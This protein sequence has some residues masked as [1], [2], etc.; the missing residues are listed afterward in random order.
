MLIQQDYSAQLAYLAAKHAPLVL[1][2]LPATVAAFTLET[3]F[4]LVQHCNTSSRFLTHLNAVAFNAF[5]LV[6]HAVMNTLVLPV[7]KVITTMEVVSSN[8][9]LDFSPILLMILAVLVQL[10]SLIVLLAFHQH[11]LNATVATICLVEF[12]LTVALSFTILKISNAFFVQ[13]HVRLA[14]LAMPAALVS[15]HMLSQELLA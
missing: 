15:L 10:V 7:F 9:Q 3:A 8:V 14:H 1:P 5:I 13:L 2:A 11:A 12:V 4:Q 6:I